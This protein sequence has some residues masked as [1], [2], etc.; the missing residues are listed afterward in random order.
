MIKNKIKNL[1]VSDSLEWYFF[2]QAFEATLNTERLF[3]LME[4]QG[5]EDQLENIVDNLHNVRKRINEKLGIGSHCNLIFDIDL[6]DGYNVIVIDRRA[7]IN[8]LQNEAFTL[9]KEINTLFNDN[10]IFSYCP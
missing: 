7:L 2:P 8:D 5:K 4:Q 6:R 9:F 3:L 1:V 10:K